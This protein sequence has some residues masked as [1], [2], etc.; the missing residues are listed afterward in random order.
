MIDTD[1]MSISLS[2]CDDFAEKIKFGPAPD[3]LCPIYSVG[4]GFISNDA[5]PFKNLGRNC[6]VPEST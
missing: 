4:W 3:P 1:G 6:L 5:S 2:Y